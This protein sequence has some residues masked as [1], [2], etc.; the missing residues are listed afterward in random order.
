MLIQSLSQ[1]LSVLTQ[2]DASGIE[3]RIRGLIYSFRL[4]SRGL[5][6]GRNV[7]FV[8]TRN[9]TIGANVSFHGN[10]YVNSGGQKGSLVIG[11]S[12]HFDQFC[13]LYAQGGLEIGEACAVAS[14]VTIYTQSNQYAA[15]PQLRVID[16]PVRYARVTIGSDVWIGANVVIL[17]GVQIGD[18]AIVAAGAVVLNDVESRDIVAGVPA[19][20]IGRRTV[21][22]S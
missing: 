17:P 19:K 16:Q 6:V 8:G 10:A 9:M 14:G 20:Q 12:S 13:V 2:R 11:A 7:Q 15:E 3:A 4:G 1:L 18:H 22:P 5:R 21:I